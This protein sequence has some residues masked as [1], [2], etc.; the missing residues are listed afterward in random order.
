MAYVPLTRAQFQF[1]ND[2]K[3]NI[4]FR[5]FLNLTILL[6]K[7]PIQKKK[8]MRSTLTGEKRL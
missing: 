7:T 1:F 3:L 6:V 8:L 2:R 5:G 4:S